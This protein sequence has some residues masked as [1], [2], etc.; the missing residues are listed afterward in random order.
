M[1]NI[2][3]DYKKNCAVNIINNAFIKLSGQEIVFIKNSDQVFMSSK[4]NYC[5]SNTLFFNVNILRLYIIV[6]I[7]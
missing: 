7:L 1:I 3:Y 2:E 5:Y 4:G 6:D